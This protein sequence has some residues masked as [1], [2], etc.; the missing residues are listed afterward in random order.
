[1]TLRILSAVQ[2]EALIRGVSIEDLLAHSTQ[3]FIRL[4]QGDSV[5]CPTRST[6][7][8]EE[9]RVLTMAAAVDDLA[10]TVKV[11]SVPSDRLQGSGGLPATIMVIDPG[12]GIPRTILN[13]R[14]LTA[15]RTAA[16][17]C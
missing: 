12:M 9:Y 4:S 1:M 17:E 15:L 3:L 13:G 5:Q 10:M 6:I 8:L 11:V 7:Q 14:H 16:G 2:V